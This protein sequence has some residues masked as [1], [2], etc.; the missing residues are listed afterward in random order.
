MGTKF[1]L[2]CSIFIQFMS[3]MV[4]QYMREEELRARHQATLLQLRERALQ[5]KTEA[6]L[7]W[8]GM[9]KKQLRSKGADDLMPP[10]VKRERGLL[11]KLQHEQVGVLSSL[12]TTASTSSHH[13]L[14]P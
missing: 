5:E 6:E 13:S 1:D 10:L 2:S 9:K 8:L 3:R 4:Q 12:M 14:P 7:E 11:K